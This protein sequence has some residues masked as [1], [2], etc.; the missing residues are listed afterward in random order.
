VKGR[1]ERILVIGGHGNLGEAIVNDFSKYFSKVVVT[2]STSTKEFLESNEKFQLVINAANRYFPEPTQGQINEMEKSIVGL[3]E[4]IKN[5]III[6]NTPVIYF[7]TYLQYAPKNLQPWSEYSEFKSIAAKFFKHISVSRGIPTTE[8]ILYDNFGG[9]RKNKIFDLMLQAAIKG[10][11]LDTSPGY[12]VVNLTHVNDIVRG[13]RESAIEILSPKS[14]IVRSYQFK[15]A[16]SYTLR[17]LELMISK[18]LNINKFVN[19][20]A[21]K[22]RGKEVFELWD[23]AES[24]RFWSETES[25]NNYVLQMRRNSPC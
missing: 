7:S 10:E 5:Y 17:E 16:K 15:S 13:I 12:S 19:W 2:G 21:V 4:S 18:T 22:Y 1:S 25:I 14:K 24:P 8:I 20:G 9:K 3:A 23:C 6:H 11:N